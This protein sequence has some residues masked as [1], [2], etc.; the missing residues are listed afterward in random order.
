MVGKNELTHAP[1]AAYRAFVTAAAVSMVSFVAY[2][3][4]VSMPTNNIYFFVIAA[5][6][7]RRRRLRMH[8][9]SAG[10]T[11]RTSRLAQIRPV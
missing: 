9:D 4:F 1:D 10:A 5:L 11:A 6:L 2:K 3:L 7:M 8:Q